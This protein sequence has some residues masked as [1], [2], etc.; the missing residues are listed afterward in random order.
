MADKHL[1]RCSTSLSG[2]CK[3]Q[4]INAYFHTSIRTIKIKIRQYQM[5]EGIEKNW[6]S[7]IVSRNAKWYNQSGK[8]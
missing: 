3:M 2:K 7:Y 8:V 1:K 4:K 6:I 5:L